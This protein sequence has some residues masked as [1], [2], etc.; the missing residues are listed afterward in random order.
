MIRVGLARVQPSYQGLTAP[1]S[2]GCAYPEMA[3]LLGTV[4]CEGPV[5][6][7]YA[8][9]RLAL[10]ALGL[11]LNRFGTP[12]W[13][14][15]G[16]LAPRGARVV[17]KPN[18]IRHWN[19]Q[20]GQSVES[21]ITHGAVIRAALDYASLAVGPEGRV[22]L[23]EAPQQDCDWERVTEIAGLS[24]MTR[25]YRDALGRDFAC[26]D[27]RR[28][29]VETRDGVIV[30]RK[31]LPGDPLG[32]RTVVPEPA[33]AAVALQVE[34]RSCAADHHQDCGDIP[35]GMGKD[36]SPAA[37]NEVSRHPASLRRKHARCSI[38]LRMCS[39]GM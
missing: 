10:A 29:A 6:H 17:L 2:P 31:Q 24:E 39:S 1:W 33:R 35:A 14:P 25:L 32:Y 36:Y 19:P 9:V 20:R 18:F 16:E 13:N 37:R 34:S 21:V 8:A 3:I 11:D 7:V 28:E 30:G 23:A 4:G 38:G 22:T 27:L 15:L 26:I 5:N 12:E